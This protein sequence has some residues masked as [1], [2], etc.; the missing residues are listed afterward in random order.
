MYL[1]AGLS[2]RV[3]APPEK[4]FLINRAR[5]RKTWGNSAMSLRGKIAIVT[6][7]ARGVGREIALAFGR[8][9]A[10]L[11]LADLN[12]DGLQEVQRELEKEGR[13]VLVGRTDVSGEA[14]LVDL[15]RRTTE[16]F[17]RIDILVNN[18]AICGM[19]PILDITVEEWD[20]FMAVNLRSVFILSKEVFRHMKERTS[21]KIVNIG[22]IAAKLGGLAAGAHYAAAKAGVICLTKSFA[23]QSAPFGINVNCVCPGPIDTEM[24]KAWGDE[25]N[26][27]Y[28]DKIPFKRYGRPRDVAEAVC[29]LA[30]DEAE[31]ITGEI[32]DVNG[33]MLMD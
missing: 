5:T 19:C 4:R 24:T 30:S 9:G 33:G 21:G 25:F 13:D 14:D 22:S 26:R 1:Q 11:S 16:R 8:R 15:V 12:L 27:A 28:A 3:P 32:L 23:L 2:G 18:A 29:F 7:A 20:R 17:G 31:Y 10:S 6:G